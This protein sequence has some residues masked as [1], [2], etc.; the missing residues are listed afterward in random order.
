MKNL[1]LTSA[2]LVVCVAFAAAGCRSLR[3]RDQLNKGV[4]A[5]RSAQFQRAIEHFRKAIELDGTLINA[6]LYLA[7]SFASQYIPGGESEEN[8]QLGEQ[9]IAEFQKIID[10]VSNDTGEQS[11]ER[12]GAMLNALAGAASIYYNMKKFDEAKQYQRRAIEADPNNPEPYYWIGV[13]NWA[14][15]FADN[16]QVRRD[17]RIRDPQKP[18]P[19]KER[20]D[21]AEKNLAVVQEGVEV[22]E[23][24]IELRP[25][26]ADAMA[27]L[28]LLLRQRADLQSDRELRTADLDS[29]DTWNKKAVDIKMAAI[30]EE[31]S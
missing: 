21:L 19:R 5:Y 7:T 3:G 10:D 26:Y 6:K 1:K 13:I 4:Q 23:K 20:E 29:A 11:Q 14:I 9:A 2:V 31:A 12:R 27:Y 8:I 28:N 17:L 16:T 30:A 24:A 18:L 22:L 25:N 15:A